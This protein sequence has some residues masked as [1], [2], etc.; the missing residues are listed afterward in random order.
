MLRF[1]NAGITIVMNRPFFRFGRDKSGARHM[2]VVMDLASASLHV[3]KP[4]GPLKA[5]KPPQRREPR[6][7]AARPPD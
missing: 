5:L 3:A 4:E 2:W 7:T 6:G 1:R